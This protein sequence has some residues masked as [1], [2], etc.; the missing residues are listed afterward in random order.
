[1]SLHSSNWLML[2]LISNRVMCV[3]GISKALSTQH[4]P[5]YVA[6][7]DSGDFVC[8][9]MMQPI[10]FCVCLCDRSESNT[11][12]A[13]LIVALKEIFL[14]VE[15]EIFFRSSVRQI[16]LTQCFEEKKNP[17]VRGGCP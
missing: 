4:Q 16:Y 12:G 11:G 17:H 5:M 7:M 3:N 1:M 15:N 2:P 9:A 10:G 14:V 8:I 6:P 13:G